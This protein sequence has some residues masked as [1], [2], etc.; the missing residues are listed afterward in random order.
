MDVDATGDTPRTDRAFAE[1]V[2]AVEQQD[3]RREEVS[4]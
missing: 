3:V 4:P 1:F 2:R